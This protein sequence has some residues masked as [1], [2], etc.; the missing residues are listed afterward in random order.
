ITGPA[1]LAG[2]RIAVSEG[3]V[4]AGL[5]HD[6]VPGAE[7]RIHRN[8]ILGLTDLTRGRA[9]AALVSWFQGVHL[10]TR[11]GLPVTA[12]G[13]PLRVCALSMSFG[14]RSP[15]F[16]R[17]VDGA[18]GGMIG[19]GTL[20]VISRRWLGGLDMAA[21]LRRTPVGRTG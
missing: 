2:R 15:A 14:R 16:L 12:V 17:A 11:H 7:V 1:H 4:R 10:A 3:T 5:T 8:A 18:V 20:T 6:R 13:P 19:D 21:E 9:D